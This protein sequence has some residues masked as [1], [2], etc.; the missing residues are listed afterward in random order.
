MAVPK[1]YANGM[2][3]VMG[4]ATPIDL[5]SDS[6]KFML[7][8]ASYT[9]NQGTDSVRTTPV[10]FEATATGW[11]AGGVALVSPTLT[12]ASLTVKWDQSDISQAITGTLAFRYGVFYK[13]VGTAATDLLVGYVDFGAQSITDAT[14]N[15]TLTDPLNVTVS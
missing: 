3:G 11:S 15:V 7:A 8:T 10:A 12:I 1:W 4:N 14:L 2:A 13:N 5:N 9:P 6:F